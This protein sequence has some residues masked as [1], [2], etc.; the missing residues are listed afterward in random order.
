MCRFRR[1]PRGTKQKRAPTPSWGTSACTSNVTSRRCSSRSEDLIR[2][3]RIE[4]DR[5]GG[6][7]SVPRSWL[8]RRHQP[9]SHTGTN[10][11]S[12][13]FGWRDFLVVGGDEF[14]QHRQR[15]FS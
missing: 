14:Q 11:Q 9:P 4:E 5:S 8:E 2:H 10:V 13:W 1:R 12:L 15:G 6:G 3:R 7:E